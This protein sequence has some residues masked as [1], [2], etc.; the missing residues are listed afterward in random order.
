[1][2]S[3]QVGIIYIIIQLYITGTLRETLFFEDRYIVLVYGQN[4]LALDGSQ[5]DLKS[6][7]I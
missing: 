6:E 7:D 2:Y 3:F 4:L 1:M 5:S